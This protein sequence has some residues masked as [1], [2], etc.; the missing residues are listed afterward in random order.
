M[1]NWFLR[2]AGLTAPYRFER[3]LAVLAAGLL[4][5]IVAAT[6]AALSA[7]GDLIR[8]TPR[9]TYFLYLGGLVLAGAALAPWPRLS[10]LALSVAVLD[11]GLGVGS[12]I[13]KNLGM[14]DSDIIADNYNE[15][16]RFKWHPLL[17][18]TP[19]PSISVPVVLNTVGHNSEGLRG[20][21][22]DAA[23]LQRQSV[24]AVFGGSTT[25]DIGVTDG[26]TWADQ[27][28]A[29]LGGEHFAVLNHGVPGYTT[30]EHVVQTA[31]Y[32]DAYGVEPRCALYY[33]GWNDLRMAHMP[34]I[35]PGYARYHLRGQI[36]ALKV[37][38][39]GGTY[40]SV[41][42]LLTLAI[43]WVSVWSDTARP[44]RQIAGEPQTGNDPGLDALYRRNVRSISRMNQ[45][46][47]IR[48][49][50][51]G[52]I[53]NVDELEN[54]KDRDGINGWI[55][56]IRNRDVWPALTHLNDVLRRE[57]ALLQDIYVDMPVADFVPEDFYDNGHFLAPGSRKFA[58]LLA[59]T[60]ARACR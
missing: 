3:L 5:I 44:A 27:L 55:P 53:L 31:F 26:E 18:A 23:T 49:I 6:A 60:V 25:Y 56:L 29:T 41:S 50:W 12:L 13:S 9:E 38:R 20:R 17:Q 30:V 7:D 47:G 28:E 33:V 11:F 34:Q 45:D 16:M 22:R 4:A 39:F 48:T 51:V 15:D 24:I 57:A 14:A 54:G 59:P 46:R 36:D 1:Q 19:I 43:R 21:E 52:Q 37:R 8:H 2:Y 40:T 32:Q 10:T 35:D 42:P 58:A